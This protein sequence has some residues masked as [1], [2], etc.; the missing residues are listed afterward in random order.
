MSNI[1]RITVVVEVYAEDVPIT[2]GGPINAEPEYSGEVLFGDQLYAGI[3][4]VTEELNDE[5]G[6]YSLITVKITDGRTFTWPVRNGLSPYQIAVMFGF[7]GTEEDWLKSLVGPRGAGA[8]INISKVHVLEPGTDPYIRNTGTETDAVFE[9][10]IPKGDKGDSWDIDPEVVKLKEDI[11]DVVY[12]KDKLVFIKGITEDIKDLD[13]TIPVRVAE[14][15][16]KI[17]PIYNVV[18]ELVDLADGI[19]EMGNNVVRLI[20]KVEG[21]NGLE[22]RVS[23]VEIKTDTF[24]TTEDINSI[25]Q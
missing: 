16:R 19:Q 18:G 21:D 22:K 6:G 14:L 24:A 15:E 4:S 10:Y 8:T 7:D 11:E 12:M 1:H 17:K 13:E 3:E 25:I 2:V 5:A 23:D 9:L 20:E